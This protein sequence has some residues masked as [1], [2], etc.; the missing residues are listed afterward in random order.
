MTEELLNYYE[1]TDAD[2]QI[3]RQRINDRKTNRKN[4][5]VE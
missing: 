2:R 5:S 3:V 1:P 4:K